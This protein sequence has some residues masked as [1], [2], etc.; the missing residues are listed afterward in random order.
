MIVSIYA[1]RYKPQYVDTL[2]WSGELECV[3]R[4]GDTIFVFD[5]W[6]GQK[7][8]RVYWDLPAKEVELFIDDRTGE[9]SRQA[10]INNPQKTKDTK[11]IKREGEV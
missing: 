11:S 10:K 3:P 9:Y 6:G 7:V 5:G 4:I 2:L 8:T 1:T